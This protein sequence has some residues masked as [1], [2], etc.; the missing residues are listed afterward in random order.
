M[1]LFVREETEEK[2][3]YLAS[4]LGG[5]DPEKHKAEARKRA[6]LTLKKYGEVQFQKQPQETIHCSNNEGRLF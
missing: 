4:K 1:S 3:E 2:F 6:D 5:S